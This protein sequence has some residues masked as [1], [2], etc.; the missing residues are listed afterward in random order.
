MYLKKILIFSQTALNV[1][2]CPTRERRY[3]NS[4]GNFQQFLTCFWSNCFTIYAQNVE[5]LLLHTH[6]V[7]RCCNFTKNEMSLLSH[8]IITLKPLPII[9]Y[10]LLPSFSTVVCAVDVC[11]VN[12]LLPSLLDIHFPR[13]I[14]SLF[15]LHWNGLIRLWFPFR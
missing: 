8:H 14:F 4:S 13:C 2:A 15:S 5:D 10:F 6:G 7:P 1:A 11:G 12:F 9:F 3:V